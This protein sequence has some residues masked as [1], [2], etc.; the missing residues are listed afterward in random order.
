MADPIVRVRIVAEDR[1]AATI[2]RVQESSRGLQTELRRL[3]VSLERDV[4]A[5]LERNAVILR[6]SEKAYQAG[7]ITLRDYER[8]QSAVARQNE[9]LN[10]RL[11]GTAPA[12]RA[13]VDSVERLGGSLQSLAVRMAASVVGVGA[14]IR[15]FRSIVKETPSFE[16]L[17]ESVSKLASRFVGAASASI[18]ASGALDRVKQSAEDAEQPVERLGSAFGL[19]FGAA[20]DAVNG[21][22]LPFTV[23]INASIE[24]SRALGIEIVS[25]AQK[26]ANLVGVRNELAPTLAQMIAGE[27]RLAAIERQETETLKE[28][29][30]AAKQVGVT[31][32]A[33]VNHRIATTA[34]VLDRARAAAQ[35]GVITWRDYE[36]IAAAA[37]ARN[38][39]LQAKL[40]GTTTA[41][42]EQKAAADEGAEGLRNY[43]NE[44]REAS[45]ANDRYA[46]SARNA[47]AAQAAFNAQVGGIVARSSGGQERI[48]AAVRAGR[49]ITLVQGGTRARILNGGSVLV[50]SG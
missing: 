32:E 20:T 41:L 42:G 33:E 21:F 46:Q 48:D 26:T 40:Q 30:A 1:A 19:V 27:E 14:L 49:Q 38:A 5:N 7:A 50:R 17:S 35:Q 25:L 29:A 18:E 37:A 23:A 36:N 22:L 3:G 39:E 47:A 43:S 31:L 45:R 8:A 4:N 9:A 10:A 44:Q 12:A 16:R 6:E 2:K 24:G 15:G 34:E 28:M 13:S 11:A